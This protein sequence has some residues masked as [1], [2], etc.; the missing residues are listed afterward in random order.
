MLVWAFFGS[1]FELALGR[2]PVPSEN[3]VPRYE[4]NA[5]MLLF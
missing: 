2:S 5:A 4:K 3:F 1:S